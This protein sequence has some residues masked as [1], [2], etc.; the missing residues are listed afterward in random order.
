M[1]YIHPR[2]TTSSRIW[3]I[4]ERPFSSDIQKGFLASGGMGYALQK[5]LEEAGI[6]VGDVYFT[7][8]RPDTD[9]PMAVGSIES[10]LHAWKPPI[11]AVVGEA[12]KAFCKEL[13]VWKDQDSFKTQLNKYAGSLLKCKD[14]PW[15]HWVMPI[16][17]IEYLMQDWTA[18]NVTT[19]VDFQKLRDEHSFWLRSG[20]VQPLKARTLL[21]HEM[22]TDEVL[23]HLRDFKA[24]PRLSE[25]IES[26]Y[27]K[28]GSK[29][30]QKHPGYP[31]TMGIAPSA[32]FGIS[33]NLFRESPAA[34]RAVWRALEE[35][36]SEA[37]EIIG[38][39]FFNFDALFISALGFTLRKERFS[40]TL[41]RAHILWPELPKKLQFLTRQYTREPY[42]KDEGKQWSLKDM[43]G[44]RRYNCLDVCCT[45]EV[46]EGQE[47]EFKAKPWL[48]GEAA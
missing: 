8:R 4:L 10:A 37:E 46:W 42:Y 30:Y 25:D 39:N 22:E 32:E 18:R 9:N 27:P 44:L 24:Y 16:Q 12:G 40:D 3:V 38:Q 15:P 29:Y 7:C 5:M 45:Y 14:W 20:T 2:G 34:S 21:S 26:I 36:N 43:S 28:S 13:E 17:S 31:I 6:G 33:F 47:E 41:L 19:Y 23:S 11:V 35:L 1:P 48:K